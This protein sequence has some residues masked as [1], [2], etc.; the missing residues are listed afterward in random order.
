MSSFV[1]LIATPFSV[2]AT[3]T[4]S[5]ASVNEA[6]TLLSAS[7]ISGSSADTLTALFGKSK[8]R[9]SRETPQ[10]TDIRLSTTNDQIVFESTLKYTGV[11][12]DLY[13]SGVLYKNEKT[14]NSGMSNNLVFAEMDDINGLHFVQFKFDKNKSELLIIL[15]FTE[16]KELLS[17]SIPLTAKTFNDFYNIEENPI[18]GRDLEEKIA[19][20]YS[21]SSN[22]IDAED[23]TTEYEWYSSTFITESTNTSSL[24]RGTFNGWADLFSDLEDGSAI[25]SNHPNVEAD[26]FKGTGWQ[27][28]NGWNLPYMVMSYSVPNGSG[29]YLT[30]FTLLDVTAQN[31]PVTSDKYKVAL[32]VKYKSG[33]LVSYNEY[34]DMLSVV[35][36]D[37]GLSFNEVYVG[38]GGLTDNAFFIDRTVSRKFLEEGNLVKAFVTL[39]PPADAVSSIFDGLTMGTNQPATEI[40]YFEQTYSAQ[41]DKYQGQIIK[42]IV[43]ST[44]GKKLTIPGHLINIGGTLIY[45]TTLGFSWTLAY[46]FYC[47]PFI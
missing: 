44:E 8:T 6:D 45:D 11:E 42:G 1:L 7:E 43:A 17:F 4:D 36:Y 30:Q 23:N 22:L 9:T 40:E 46:K 2:H 10:L 24:L 19:S 31:Y 37:F 38:I 12:M 5:N 21:A 27:N 13:T 20:L 41:L 16:S 32:Q 39:Y 14:E 18:S 35:Y 25:L 47:S 26:F 28:D 34:T 29:E 15:Q 33:A 3:A